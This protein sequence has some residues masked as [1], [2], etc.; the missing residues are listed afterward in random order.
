MPPR[1]LANPASAAGTGLIRPGPSIYDAFADS[2]QGMSCHGKTATTFVLIFH[3]GASTCHTSKRTNV[4]AG[5]HL[6]LDRAFARRCPVGLTGPSSSSSSEHHQSLHQQSAPEEHHRPGYNRQ[7]SRSGRQKVANPPKP[8]RGGLAQLVSTFDH[9]LEESAEPCTHL[10]PSR[11]TPPKANRDNASGEYGLLRRSS[12]D[13]TS[14]RVHSP[15][16]TL[17]CPHLA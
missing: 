5:N 6:P 15:G 11:S 14:V 10:L 9:D 12:L 16:Y 3:N 7:R 8:L 17:R 1:L 2:L 4:A 13:V